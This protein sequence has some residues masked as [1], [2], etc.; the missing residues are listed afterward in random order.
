MLC[1]CMRFYGGTLTD[2]RAC[3][4][5]DFVQCCAY[6]HPLSAEEAIVSAVASSIP[7][8]KNGKRIIRE[9][10][11]DAHSRDRA[12]AASSPIEYDILAAQLGAVER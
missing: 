8:S 6:I 3:R 12:R 5:V 9:W 11:H 4:W 7:H 10:Q 2:W 1:R